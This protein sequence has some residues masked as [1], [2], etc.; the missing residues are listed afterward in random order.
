MLKRAA[1]IDIGPDHIIIE[2]RYRA[3]GAFNDLLIALWFLTGSI[4]FFYESMMTDGTWLF[5]AGSLQLLLRPAITLIEL[6]HVDRVRK[7]TY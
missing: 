7:R 2:R 3:L 5:V 1:E 4:F 6:I